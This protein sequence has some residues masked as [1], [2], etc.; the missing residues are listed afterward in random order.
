VP[1]E[2]YNDFEEFG[3]I[4]Q[5]HGYDRYFWSKKIKYLDLDGWCYWHFGMGPDGRY[6]LINRAKL[7]NI[8]SEVRGRP[9]SLPDTYEKDE[10]EEYRSRVVV[11]A[12]RDRRKNVHTSS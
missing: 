9:P 4:I 10:W 1:E 11:E 7:P 2:L 3:G 8:A 12:Y 5:I 6:G